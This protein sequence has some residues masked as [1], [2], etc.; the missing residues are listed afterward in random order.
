MKDERTECGVSVSGQQ[1]RGVGLGRS[2]SRAWSRD[3]AR[4]VFVGAVLGRV[5]AGML[6]AGRGRRLGARRVARRRRVGVSSGAA[7]GLG[8]HGASGSGSR[9]RAESPARSRAVASGGALGA[10]MARVL[11][12]G[13]RVAARRLGQGLSPAGATGRERDARGERK[14][15]ERERNGRG[16]RVPGGTSERARGEREG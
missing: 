5:R 3:T 4:G 14:L 13:G 12:A 15:G 11:G 2:G 8:A 9:R 1:G 6:G 16:G 7:R 10:L